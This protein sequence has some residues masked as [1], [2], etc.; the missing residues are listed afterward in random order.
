MNLV[1]KIL[2][3]TL[4]LVAVVI[5]IS[6][7]NSNEVSSTAD[8]P[9]IHYTEAFD[10]EPD[11]YFVYFWNAACPACQQFD[12][13]VMDAHRAGIPIFVVD[14]ANAD[15]RSAWYDWEGHHEYFTTI[16]GDVE[17]GQIVFNDGMSGDRFPTEDGW[18][19]NVVGTQAIAEMQQAQ[20]NTRPRD[21]S[22]IEVAG[23]PE[24]L[25]IVD[26]VVVGQSLNVEPGRSLFGTYGQ[27]E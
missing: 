8:L 9:L 25:R 20:N 27:G 21:A 2:I 17:N 12:P 22:E 1:K 5:G 7:I 11:E 10:Q 14:M 6:I 24:L 3:G 19:I 18:V 4:A 13:D 16:V 26:G 23:T 15:N